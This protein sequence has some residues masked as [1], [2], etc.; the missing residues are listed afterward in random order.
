[1]APLA[2]VP[3]HAPPPPEFQPLEK[4]LKT[5]EDE[6]DED[7]EWGFV[8]TPV[9]PELLEKYKR[10]VEESEVTLDVCNYLTG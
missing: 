4:K 2:A 8:P 6:E 5:E 10:Q 3:R 1:M 9:D 7:D